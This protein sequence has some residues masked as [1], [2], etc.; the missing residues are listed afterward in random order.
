MLPK[1]NFL[2]H[3]FLA[4]NCD[5]S[6]VSGIIKE[7]IDA[8]KKLALNHELRTNDRKGLLGSIF[9]HL[10]SF[11]SGILSALLATVSSIVS[12]LPESIATAL[13]GL[14]RNGIIGLLGG[15]AKGLNVFLRKNS[16]N[17]IIGLL[18]GK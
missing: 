6:N 4:Q 5:C 2:D 14:S 12:N 13:K 8:A 9:A 17:A 7:K 11:L 3:F 18:T 16:A 1:F 15:L 10:G